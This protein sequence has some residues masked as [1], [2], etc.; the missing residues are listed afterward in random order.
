MKKYVI[1]IKNYYLAKE[2]QE[3]FTLV[4]F[5]RKIEFATKYPDK[6]QADKT[7]DEYGG[8]TVEVE[9]DE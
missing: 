6:K 7:A 1:A 2:E 9:I 5:P 4:N 3:G 8:K